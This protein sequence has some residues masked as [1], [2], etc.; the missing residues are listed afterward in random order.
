MSCLRV[1]YWRCFDVCWVAGAWITV[2]LLIVVVFDDRMTMTLTMTMS[3]TMMMMMLMHF[4]NIL[5]FLWN[6]LFD[7]PPQRPIDTR[8]LSGVAPPS[9]GSASSSSD[10]TDRTRLGRSKEARRH[11]QKFSKQ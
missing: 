10:T 7:F 2:L 9:A 11:K 6:A 5:P 3:M 4:N 1:Y 8:V